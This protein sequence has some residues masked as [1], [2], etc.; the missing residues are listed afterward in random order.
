MIIRRVESVY[1]GQNKAKKKQKREAC[2]ICGI[3]LVCS[4]KAG[5][6]ECLEKLNKVRLGAKEHYDGMRELA[7]NGLVSGKYA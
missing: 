7:E 6:Q 2:K 5:S 1:Q 4:K 3:Q